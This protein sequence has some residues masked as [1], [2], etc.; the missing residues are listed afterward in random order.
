MN[1]LNISNLFPFGDHCGPGIII[2]DIL[3]DKTKK[4]FMLGFFG[5]NQIVDYI[6]NNDFESIYDIQYLVSSDGQALTISDD[7]VSQ[8]GHDTTVK[9]R[10]YGFS[11][12]HD[13]IV[14]EGK[15][16]NYAFI[17]NS[18][19]KKIEHFKASLASDAPMC[20]ITFTDSIDDLRIKEMN[21]IKKNAYFF[22][23]TNRTFSA[24]NVFTIKLYNNITKWWML[25]KTKKDILYNEIY[26]KFI[27]VLNK[28]N[29]AH[30]FPAPAIKAEVPMFRRS[31]NT[32]PPINTGVPW[33]RRRQ[34][35]HHQ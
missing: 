4:L 33:F 17:V 12:N 3:H 16:L 23:F 35:N 20:F 8:Y 29:I 18:Y 19:K 28:N 30:A 10:K 11:F 31:R 5:F 24:P 2:N 1:S 9:H 21:A 13:F 6:K 15:I 34:I 25:E 7:G 26:S 27:N 32:H 14:K 22:I